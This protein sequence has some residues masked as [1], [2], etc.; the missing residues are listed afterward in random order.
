MTDDELKRHAAATVAAIFG[1]LSCSVVDATIPETEVL[2]VTCSLREWIVFNAF[3]ATLFKAL[4]K[5]QADVGVNDP[6][7]TRARAA[8][9]KIEAQVDR[10]NRV[11]AE[12][13]KARPA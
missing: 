12:Q 10:M 1:E 6:L 3:T 7:F 13:T 2:A 11:I 4:A 5:A 8:M 9:A